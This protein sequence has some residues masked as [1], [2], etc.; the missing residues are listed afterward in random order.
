MATQSAPLPVRR[1]GW[2]SR[3]A[4][5]IRE[6]RGMPRWVFWAGLG[7][8]ALFVVL[9]VAAPLISPYPFDEY[10][11][12]A[13]ERFPKQGAPSLEHLFG[14]TVQSTDV[15][16]RVIFGAST[17]IEVVLLSVA[18]A[19]VIGLP[20]GLVS[21]FYGG[22]LDR[23][24]LLIM[25]ALFAFPYLLLAIVISFL[26]SGPV[27]RGIFTAAISISVVYVPQY[28]RVVRNHVISVRE[29][30]YVEA[31]TALGARPRS[32]ISRYVLTNVIQN[33]PVVATLNA[34]DAILT[35]AALGFLGYGIQPTDAAEWGY[36]LQRALSD[37]GAGIWWTGLFPG[38]AI[39]ALVTGLTLLGEG[40]NDVLNPILRRG[41]K[42]KVT[43]PARA[44][45]AESG[46]LPA[47][48][49]GDQRLADVAA[50]ERR[51]Q[52]VSRELTEL[53]IER[54]S[55]E[56]TIRVR[57]LQ[58]WYGSRTGPVHAVDGVSFEIGR[59]ETLGLV[60][61][62]G[63]GKSSLARAL[64][65]L[66]P[67]GTAT[68][69]EIWYG[70]R[71]LV[72]AST[73]ELRRVRGPEVGLVFQ[74]PM[75]RLDP[76]MRIR[77]HFRETLRAHEPD[78]S[79]RE[80]RHRALEALGGMG[81]PP[82]RYDQYP[83]EFSGGMRQRIMIAL[84]LVLRPRLVIADEPTTALDVI[85]EAQIMG[86]LRDMQA[87]FDTSLLLITHNLG[88]VASACDRIAVMYAGRLAE[89]GPARTVLTRPQHPYTR[90]LLHSTVSMKTTELSY[91]PGA[92]PD[93]V[94]PPTGCRFHPRCPDAMRVC[95][96]QVPVRQPA[97]GGGEVWCWLRG[98][99][100]EIPEGGHEPMEREEI[101]VAEEA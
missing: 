99:E 19:L 8:T 59:G 80:V 32:V 84:A 68:A 98:P 39:V 85:V 24:L 46:A 82:T 70:N 101:A 11:N 96:L 26:L 71:N 16:S 63:C 42:V 95:P 4:T 64:L 18:F 83:H 34:A 12:A 97:P 93:L 17:A 48:P 92:P 1:K 65:G 44:A 74:E 38:L 86:I 62:S 36:D 15:L 75:T 61:E 58:V 29:E 51:G 22:R 87:N 6:A 23:L 60:G 47:S 41:G 91:I 69:G 40:M 94:D 66:L 30:P 57:D 33:V 45:V 76:L 5:P 43:I 25:D 89:Q 2:L 49:A 13:G 79:D 54:A 37:A 27:G 90:E 50:A 100:S 55:G 52:P 67:S 7:I 88:L 3:I 9:A 21:G 53:P 78:I 81:I 31:A 28:F 10:R 72:G 35:L 20:L 73:A 56:P 77:D 14:T